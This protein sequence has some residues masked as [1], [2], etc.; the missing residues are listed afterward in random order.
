MAGEFAVVKF[1]LAEDT[2]RAKH[3]GWK[4]EWVPTGGDGTAC[5]EPILMPDMKVIRRL[6]AGFFSE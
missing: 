5:G 6:A 4:C 3:I 1:V 2:M